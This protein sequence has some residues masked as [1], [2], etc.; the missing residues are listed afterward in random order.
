[1]KCLACGSEQLHAVV[2]LTRLIPMADRNGTVKIGGMKIGQ[3]DMKQEWDQIDTP[4]G[5][6]ERMIRGPILCVDCESRHYYVVKS[7]NPLRLGS[8]EEALARG[9]DAIVNE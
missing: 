7:K 3:A 5:L 4:G 6:V 9:Y 8:Y 1:M 2:T